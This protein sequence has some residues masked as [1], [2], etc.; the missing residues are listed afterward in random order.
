MVSTQAGWDQNTGLHTGR[1]GLKYMSPH[2][3]DGIKIVVSMQ[4]GRDQNTGLH[5]SRM[6][7]K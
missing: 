2:K 5:T 7:S 4:V 3:L 6:G 1:M